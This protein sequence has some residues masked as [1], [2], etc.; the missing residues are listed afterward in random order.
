MA[1][2]EFIY[3][4]DGD[5]MADKNMISR[6]LR[7]MKKY[8]LDMCCWGFTI[9][10]NGKNEIKYPISLG[11]TFRF[12]DEQKKLKFICRIFLRGKIRWEVWSRAY[13]REIIEKYGIRFNENIKI[14]EDLDFTLRYLLHSQ[15]VSSVAEKLYFYRE[16]ETSTMGKFTREEQ[17]LDTVK[18]SHYQM[19]KEMRF[20]PHEMSYAAS[21][22]ATLGMTGDILKAEEQIVKLDEMREII[23]TSGEWDFFERIASQANENKLKNAYGYVYGSMLYGFYSYM[24][25]G[26]KMDYIEKTRVYFAMRRVY[27]SFRNIGRKLLRRNG[28]G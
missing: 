3:F 6:S 13:K 16:R 2:G 15:K 19:E 7:V 4:V 11:K 8:N 14:G 21:P 10:K 5:D 20:I 1:R 12:D 28:D 24:I 22:I 26:N 18:M 9:L 27:I 17:V 25:T 23:K